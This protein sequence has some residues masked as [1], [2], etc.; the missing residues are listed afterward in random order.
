MNA[1]ATMTLISAS[2]LESSPSSSYAEL[3]RAV[4]GMNVTQTSARDINL[5]V[6]LGDAARSRPRSSR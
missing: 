2:T 4:P 6:A 3:L 5:V 1:P